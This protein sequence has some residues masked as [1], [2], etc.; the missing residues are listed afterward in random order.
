LLA[1]ISVQFAHGAEGAPQPD[2]SPTPIEKLETSLEKVLTVG[3]KAPTPSEKD[4]AR[5]DQIQ[6]AAA[7]SFEKK[8]T[9][10]LKE[11]KDQ[12]LKFESKGDERRQWSLFLAMSGAVAGAVIGPAVLA[13]GGS[14][15]AGA[16]FSGYSGFSNTAQQSLLTYDMTRQESIS[17]REGVRTNAIKALQGYAQLLGQGPSSTH[18]AG[19][20]QYANQLNG[21]LVEAEISCALYALG[22]KPLTPDQLNAI[23]PK[24]AAGSGA[25]GAATP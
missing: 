17:D 6:L 24:P 19:R 12:L 4:S 16:I 15:V 23:S 1:I 2:S 22:E 21:K 18:K 7:N 14:K 10:V 13:G 11:C 20:E 9:T 8:Y 5:I 25:A 3:G